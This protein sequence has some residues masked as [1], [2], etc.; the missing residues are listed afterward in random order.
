MTDFFNNDPLDDFFPSLDDED[1]GGGLMEY[2]S[3]PAYQT[4]QEF[5]NSQQEAT[6]KELQEKYGAQIEALIIEARAIIVESEETVNTAMEKAKIID[7]INKSIENKR[8]SIVDEPNAYVKAVNSLVKFFTSKTESAAKEIK[9]KISAYNTKV[10]N[11]QQK[12]LAEERRLIEEQQRLAAEKA[13]KEREEWE[14]KQAELKKANAKAEL[15]PPPPPAPPV[16]PLPEIKAVPKTTR[17]E[18]GKATIVEKWTYEVLDLEKVPRAYLTLNDKAV[19][20][21]I[22]GGIRNIE[23]LRIFTEQST[24]FTY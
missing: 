22:S 12:K 21:A 7:K 24:R 2:N 13:R 17:T 3:E 8:K 5:Y 14:K 20:G 18:A 4:P 16:I 6:K 11:E 1:I 9:D 15:P 23:G 10:Y 19:K